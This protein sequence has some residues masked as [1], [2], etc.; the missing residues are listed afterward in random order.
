MK[1]RNRLYLV[2][3]GVY[4]QLGNVWMVSHDKGIVLID[5]G[6]PASYETILENLRYWGYTEK[7]VTHVLCTHGHDDHA[8]TASFFQK[9]GAKIVVGKEDAYMLEDGNFGERSPFRNHSM[10]SCKPDILLE[11]DSKMNIGGIDID[12]YAM[13]GHT[14]G[15]VIYVM[16]VDGETWLFSGDMFCLSGERGD[17]AETWWKGD[18]D[19]NAASLGESFAKLWSLQLKPDFIGGGHGN[20]RIGKGTE[21]NIMIAYKYYLQNHR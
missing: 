9:A 5:C 19:F 21:D 15:T 6:A 14:R 7:D 13:P 2:S 17:I 18:M 3:G 10:P 1:I 4:G 11:G 8:G 12:I 20:P 16:H